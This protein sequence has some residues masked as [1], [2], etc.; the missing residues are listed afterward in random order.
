M[1]A[2]IKGL[3]EAYNV[4]LKEGDEGLRVPVEER[5]NYLRAKDE[6]P[7][8]DITRMEIID[9]RPCANCE[10]KGI[11][12]NAHDNSRGIPCVKC[13]GARMRG[14]EVI[15]QSKHVEVK[16]SIQDNG[17]TLK[18]FVDKREEPLPRKADAS[19]EDFKDFMQKFSEMFL[20]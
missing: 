18:L 13:Q 2:I 15:F 1:G 3:Q 20:R 6:N 12:I 17:K 14:R 16:S 5:A 8:L 4:A 19:D 11:I 7:M 10:G 9:Y